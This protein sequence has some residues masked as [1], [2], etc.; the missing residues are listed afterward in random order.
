MH[1]KTRRSVALLVETSLGSGREILRGI[2]NYAHQ[3]DRWQIYHAARGLHDGVPDWMADWNGDG[4]IARVQDRE[5]ADALQGFDIPVVDVLGVADECGL[6]LVHVDDR[7]IAAQVAEH[8]K[9]REFN[10]FGFYGIE[11][12]NWSEKR[13]EGFREACGAGE[14]LH[15]L[16]TGRGE[17]DGSE[18][19][20]T[21]LRRWLRQL[22]TPI[23]LMVCSDQRGLAVLEA[24][25]EE[26]IAVPERVA[27]V[28]VDNDS[29]LCEVSSPRLSSV[30]AGHGKVGFEAA[31]LL[32]ALMAGAPPPSEVILVPPTG[33]VTRR[34]SSTNAITDA[35]VAEGIHFINENLAAPL[36]NE[37]IAKS[38][39]TSRT[40]FQRRFREATG[41]TVR[42]YLV[43]TRLRRAKSLI[44]DTTMTL[45]EIAEV[46]GFRHQEYMGSVFKDRLGITP[47]SLR[48]AADRQPQ[49]VSG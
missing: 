5:T 2:A 12:E 1:K 25:R 4:I 29:L 49:I 48:K 30:R 36:T 40:A 3:I 9:D 19:S 13:R 26:G 33:V 32:D 28:S 31:R 10:N 47:G 35:V 24:C 37:S 38:A 11:G 23:A 42:E 16:E 22:P 45:V 7:A 18:G 21:D 39:G 46:S 17:G 27:I 8:F 44:E 34:S 20:R 41:M 6:P 15:T 43:S 14:L